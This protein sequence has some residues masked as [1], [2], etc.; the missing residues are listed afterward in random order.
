[1]KMI[2]V[3]L[4]VLLVGCVNPA[5]NEFA[6]WTAAERPRAERGEIKW[7]D[8]YRD[9]YARLEKLPTGTRG[10]ADGMLF[11]ATL[12]TVALQYER[13]QID[14]ELFEQIQRTAKAKMEQ[15]A[16]AEA[17]AHRR[18]MGQAFGRALQNFGNAAYGPEATKAQ[19]YPT[20]PA[21]IYQPPRQTNCQ[22]L[23]NQTSCTTQ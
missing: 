10:K 22:T 1:M 20:A 13:G 23:G 16:E 3:L 7:S 19:Q 15:I 8:Y 4:A 2:I 6:D 21:P 17:I 12:I 14:K 18:S 11:S 5:V 9:G